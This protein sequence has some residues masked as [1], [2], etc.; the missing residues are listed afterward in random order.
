MENMMSESN[1]KWILEIREDK[2]INPPN[3][4]K[5]AQWENIHNFIPTYLGYKIA[6]GFVM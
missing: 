6:P 3:W 4:V 2:H 1:T 5:H